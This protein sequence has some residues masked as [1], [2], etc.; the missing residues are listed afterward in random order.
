MWLGATIPTQAED[1]PNRPIH[2]IV[3]TG[4]GGITDVLA[5]LV[6]ERLSK[7]AGQPVIVENRSGAGGVLGSDYVA[8]SAPDGYTLLFA[9][10][11][12]TVNAALFAK[13]PYDTLES[14]DPVTMI[15]TFP[16]VLEVR[17][18]FPAT[19]LQDLIAVAKSSADPLNYASVGNGSLAFLSAELLALEAHVALVQA[20]YKSVPE[21]AWALQSGDVEI[22]FDTPVTALPLIRAGKVRALAVTSER[23]QRTMP[24]VPAV[25]ETIPGYKAIGWNGVLAPRDTPRPVIERL[26]QLIVDILRTPEMQR[27]LAAMGVEGAG[28]TPEEFDAAI[29]SDIAKWS[30]LIKRAGIQPE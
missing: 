25:S 5:R 23:R 16:G 2:L 6:G 10:P 14:F 27:D 1:F 7:S 9:F 21:A 12:H 17:P 29:R 8:R 20:P 19:T 13:L 15:S 30:A 3:P 18:N 22:F 11:S 28:N 26:N 4:A 24:D